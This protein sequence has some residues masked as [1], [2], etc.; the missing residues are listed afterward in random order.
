DSPLTDLG[1]KQAERASQA[2]EMLKIKPATI[3]HSNLSRARETAQIINHTLNVPMIED[4]GFAEK[5]CGIKEGRP[6]A[7]V[8][9]EFLKWIDIEGG[10]TA[11]SFFNRVK[12]AK[13]KALSDPKTPILITCHG[14]VMRAVGAIHGLMDVRNIK[15]CVLYE[16]EPNLSKTSFPWDVYEYDICDTSGK[17]LRKKS[18]NYNSDS[19]DSE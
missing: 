14:G 4:A 11:Q 9:D 2:V 1:R 6:Y 19:S 3:Y 7:E 12:A 13:I 5:H 16:F 10:E 15:N 18:K 17:L 8:L